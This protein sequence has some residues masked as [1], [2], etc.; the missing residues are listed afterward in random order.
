M[1]Q[2]RFFL[3]WLFAVTFT[4]L[5]GAQSGPSVG[6]GTFKPHAEALYVQCESLA[7]K[8][9][10]GI[11][12]KTDLGALK[13]PQVKVR[14]EAA[15]RLARSCDRRAVLPLL[16]VL[17]NDVEPLARAAAVKALGQ[18][19][20]PESIDLLREAISDPAWQVRAQLGLS[21]CSFQVHRSSYDA[22]NQL[23]N[24]VDQNIADLSDLFV[25]SQA[26]LAVNQLR[27]VN[28][29]RK[30]VHFLIVLADH[31]RPEYREMAGQIFIELKKTRN[32][33]HELVG[34]LKQNLNPSFR[35]KAAQWIARLGIAS[36]EEAL[37][38]AAAEDADP[39][40]RSAA[41]AALAQL[42]QDSRK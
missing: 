1:V 34:V 8:P 11:G 42:R 29:S 25:R 12:L 3:L 4:S 20:D 19:G 23:G 33:A 14:I 39:R 16:S 28:F 38:E 37:T 5:A 31:D 32:G 2:K 7:P 10:G 26:L 6:A 18:L 27:D 17:K 30:A 35:V 36:A 13:S 41:T 21:L 15:E 24:P 9:S 22:L 40:V